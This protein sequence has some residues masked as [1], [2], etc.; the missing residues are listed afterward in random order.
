[1]MKLMGAATHR[2]WEEPMWS[3]TEA[4]CSLYQ[5]MGAKQVMVGALLGSLNWE[6]PV[7]NFK[8]ILLQ[9]KNWLAQKDIKLTIQINGV[10]SWDEYWEDGGI[11]SKIINNIDGMQDVWINGLLNWVNQ[12][13][14]NILD[15]ANE[16]AGTQSDIT[17]STYLQFLTRCIRA[18]HAVNPNIICVVTGMPFWDLKPLI[19]AGGVN[20][21][22][23]VYAVHY[24]YRYEGTPPPSWDTVGLAYW[25]AQ[26]QTD[27]ANAKQL[28]YNDLLNNEG[29]ALAQSKG[30]PVWLEEL[31][32][33]N[34]NP[35]YMQFMKDAFDFCKE[36]NLDFSLLL[37][38]KGYKQGVF[39]DDY[40]DLNEI[41]QLAKEYMREVTKKGY[42]RVHAFK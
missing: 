36:R 39:N 16:F 17:L 22:N 10:Y 37:N 38:Y 26:T 31:G 20:E 27:L 23:I 4:L 8:N 19:N 29:I 7:G 18:V 21:P 11:K 12:V 40:T 30:L 35:N 32:T 24:Y 28:L 3:K 41:G 13:N 6:S 5:S 34:Y 9:Y 2:F 33:N 15:V 25:N 14:P 1:M 42:L